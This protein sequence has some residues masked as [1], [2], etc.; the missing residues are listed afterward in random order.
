ME[1]LSVIVAAYNA[2]KYIER[3][4]NSIISQGVNAEIIVVD[5]GSTDKTRKILEGYKD[6]V[7]LIALDKNGGSVSAARNIGLNHASGGLIAF[8]DADDWYMPGAF[9]RVLELQ[10]KSDADIIRFSYFI[11][12][13]DGR[14]K[15]PDER[16]IENK[17]ITK[18]A[19]REKIYPYFVN[20]I[21]LNSVWGAVFKRQVIENIR[22][23]LNFKTAEDAAFAV[24]AYTRAESVLLCNEPLYCYY[25]HDTSLTGLG[26]SIYKKYK[27]NFYLTRKILRFLPQW[28]MDTV[29]WRIKTILR[30][31][32]LTA[33]KIRRLK[34]D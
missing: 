10:T 6:K 23:P 1:K 29:P 24:E 34:N 22:F 16:I 20:G 15:L 27:Y 33:S 3:C 8:C 9:K 17:L 12:F 13:P 14:R 7:K 19:F 25:R 11:T 4:V 26:L 18:T 21:V 5:D 32:K 31:L 2:E 30:P 28:G